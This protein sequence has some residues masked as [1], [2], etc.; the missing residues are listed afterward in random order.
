M[1]PRV[2]RWISAKLRRDFLSEPTSSIG[3]TIPVSVDPLKRRPPHS[4]EE[5]RDLVQ[6]ACALRSAK[7]S[8]PA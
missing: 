2:I 4:A 6:R 8:P 5:I 1:R 3:R 7:S